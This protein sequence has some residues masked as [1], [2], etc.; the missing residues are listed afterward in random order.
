MDRRAQHPFRLPLDGGWDRSELRTGAGAAHMTRQLSSVCRFR[1]LLGI[2]GDRK[3][4]V[5]VEIN[6]CLP[7]LDG[8]YV[9]H[10][11]D[12]NDDVLPLLPASN[13]HLYESSHKR[14]SLIAETQDVIGF[15]P[16][17]RE[18]RVRSEAAQ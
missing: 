9:P 13:R 8:A 17:C 1:D 6:R 14:F 3:A 10:K 16:I 11:I 5:V 2:H 12:V 15:I 4:L 7:G 18:G